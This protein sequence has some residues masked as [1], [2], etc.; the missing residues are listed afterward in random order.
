MQCC[1]NKLPL[2]FTYFFFAKNPHPKNTYTYMNSFNPQNTCKQST[3]S[4]TYWGQAEILPDYW[5]M[6]IRENVL[7]AKKSSVLS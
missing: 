6:F 7:A 2:G 3:H 4:F 5:E 1:S